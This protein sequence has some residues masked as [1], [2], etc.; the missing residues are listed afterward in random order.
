MR[1]ERSP[2]FTSPRSD[3]ICRGVTE[4][5]SIFFAFAPA[6]RSGRR[7]ACRSAKNA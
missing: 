5:F 6:G 1:R 2:W 4:N 3:V 7:P